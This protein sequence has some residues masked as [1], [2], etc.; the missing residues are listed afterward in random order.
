MYDEA[1]STHVKRAERGVEL[2][3]Q[4][5]EDAQPYAI[6]FELD[7]NGRGLWIRQTARWYQTGGEEQPVVL[8]TRQELNRIVNALHAIEDTVDEGRGTW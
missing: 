3:Q 2:I 7:G 8:I 1:M 6:K 5:N 4:L